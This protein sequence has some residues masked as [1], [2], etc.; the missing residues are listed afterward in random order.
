M[1]PA[2]VAAGTA[3]TK[4]QE[5]RRLPEIQEYKT[6]F[7]LT[8]AADTGRAAHTTKTLGHRHRD[9]CFAASDALLLAAY[10]AF[11]AAFFARFASSAA[12]IAGRASPLSWSSPAFVCPG[13]A[14][15]AAAG[16]GTAGR[17]A[18]AAATEAAPPPVGVGRDTAAVNDAAAVAEGG[19]DAPLASGLGDNGS[20]STSDGGA[21]GA[22]DSGGATGAGGGSGSG[23]GSV[24]GGSVGAS[25]SGGDT[26]DAVSCLAGGGGNASGGCDTGVGT[27]LGSGTGGGVG[28]FAGGAAGA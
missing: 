24:T 2:A 6:V 10:L 4:A 20:G 8:A 25:G 19:L 14:R 11:N 28:S 27:T 1:A 22:C 18:G 3:S 21:V 15:A 7:V 13:S 5:L 17:G 12:V 26:G 9:D 23:S 16:A